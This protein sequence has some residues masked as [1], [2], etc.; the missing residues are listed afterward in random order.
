MRVSVAPQCVVV[1]CSSG[2]RRCRHWRVPGCRIELLPLHLSPHAPCLC[3]VPRCCRGRGV[4]AV[5]L[6][7]RFLHCI[8]SCALLLVS[9]VFHCV[10]Y[11]VVC[12]VHALRMSPVCIASTVRQMCML[13]VRCVGVQPTHG[14]SPHAHHGAWNVDNQII[15]RRLIPLLCP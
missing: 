10:V 13:C 2:S 14:N 9:C 5:V 6:P 12:C 1:S 7:H 8:M 4:A 11:C 3:N 15:H